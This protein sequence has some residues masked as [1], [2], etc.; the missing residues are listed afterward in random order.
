MVNTIGFSLTRE[1]AA[2]TGISLYLRGK[3][4]LG[5][6]FGD[7]FGGG[8]RMEKKIFGAPAAPQMVLTTSAES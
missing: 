2:F 5:T 1:T 6:A 7:T 3:A 8:D 4:A